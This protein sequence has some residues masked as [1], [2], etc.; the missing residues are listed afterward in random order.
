MA[1]DLLARITAA[2]SRG[3]DEARQQLKALWDDPAADSL[4]R[5][6]IAHHLADLQ[7]TTEE[8]LVWDL[9]ALDAVQEVTDGRVQQVH[10]SLRVR[11]FLPSLHLNLADDYRRLGRFDEAAGQLDAARAA[12]DALPDDGYGAM[13]RGGVERVAALLEEA[14]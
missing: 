9:R 1:D 11:G 12:L 14:G 2:V 5:C 13:I 8:E 7:T 4:H 3:P 10:D 6:T